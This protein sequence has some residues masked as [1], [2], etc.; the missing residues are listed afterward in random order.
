M[1]GVG[2]PLLTAGEC[3]TRDPPVFML[4]YPL[5][6]TM[7]VRVAG[8]RERVEEATEAG[9]C[10]VAMAGVPRGEGLLR[11]SGAALFSLLAE[12]RPRVA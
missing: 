7:G 4:P 10:G 11:E 3:T 12:A 5:L 2:M 1:D 9:V 8:V 6:V